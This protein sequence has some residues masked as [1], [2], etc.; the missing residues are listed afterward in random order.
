[1]FN[2]CFCTFASIS[3]FPSD[4]YQFRKV[5]AN[6]NILIILNTIVSK[7][8]TETSHFKQKLSKTSEPI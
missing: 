1:M 8:Y 7:M 2:I 5:K 6:T 3:K 4:C